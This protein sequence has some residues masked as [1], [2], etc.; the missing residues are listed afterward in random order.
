MIDL[1]HA[2]A[3]HMKLGLWLKKN[4]TTTHIL[5]DKSVVRFWIQIHPYHNDNH[6]LTRQI[7]LLR[8]H[9]ACM[10]PFVECTVMHMYMQSRIQHRILSKHVAN[11]K[12]RTYYCSSLYHGTWTHLYCWYIFKTIWQLLNV[13]NII[14]HG[15]GAVVREGRYHNKKHRILTGYKQISYGTESKY[16]LYTSSNTMKYDTSSRQ[17]LYHSLIRIVP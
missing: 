10:A 17:L 11:L 16:A 12:A 13:A 14:Q 5:G 9:M 8:K 7:C 4:Q 1:L 6:S 15:T 2:Q 3:Y